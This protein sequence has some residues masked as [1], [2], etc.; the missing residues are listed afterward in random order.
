MGLAEEA[1]HQST[2]GQVAGVMH[3]ACFPA[4]SLSPS[5]AFRGTAH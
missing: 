1:E 4:L 5:P 3:A 2:G